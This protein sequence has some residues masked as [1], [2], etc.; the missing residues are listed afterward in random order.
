MRDRGATRGGDMGRGRVTRGGVRRGA[1]G[2]L[3]IKRAL[4]ENGSEVGQD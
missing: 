4:W 2:V 3:R 1:G